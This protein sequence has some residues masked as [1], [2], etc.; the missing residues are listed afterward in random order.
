MNGIQDNTTELGIPGVTLQIFDDSNDSG[1]IEDYKDLICSTA[2]DDL[3][4]YSCENIVDGDYISNVTDDDGITSDSCQEITTGGKIVPL[5]VVGDTVANVG[6][7]PAPG[8]ISGRIW[9]DR[10]RTGNINEN[11]GFRA[12]TTVLISIDLAVS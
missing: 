10:L 7:F 3:G 1:M 5:D 4:K 11:R 2:S 8:A 9:Y 12:V 6:F